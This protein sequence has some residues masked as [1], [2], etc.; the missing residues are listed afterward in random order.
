PPI[1]TS[2]VIPEHN[3][4]TDKQF[5]TE[6]APLLIQNAVRDRSIFVLDHYNNLI[7]DKSRPDILSDSDWRIIEAQ[8]T[9]KVMSDIGHS[10]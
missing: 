3:G 10:V 7:P 2:R 9:D 1:N 8:V 4:I 5:A 6:V